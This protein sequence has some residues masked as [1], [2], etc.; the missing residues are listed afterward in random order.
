MAKGNSIKKWEN[1]KPKKA[2]KTKR[3]TESVF[4]LPDPVAPRILP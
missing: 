4:C 2:K 3:F 1:E